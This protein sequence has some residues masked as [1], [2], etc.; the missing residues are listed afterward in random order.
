MFGI[1][2]ETI[3]QVLADIADIKA[4]QAE[5]YSTMQDKL[6][7]INAK[8]EDIVAKLNGQSSSA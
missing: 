7:V 8:L 2:P 5:M 3:K 1:D 4:K 6:N